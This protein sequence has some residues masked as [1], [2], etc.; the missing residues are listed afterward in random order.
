MGMLQLKKRGVDPKR[1]TDKQCRFVAEYA[2]D[3]TNGKAA[4]IR[5]G[6]PAKTAHVMASR[7][8]NHPLVS[9]ALGNIKRQQL[10][11]I[12]LRREEILEQLL[13]AVTRDVKDMVDEDGEVLS[14]PDMPKRMR[15]MIDG[16]D[17]EVTVDGET[18]DRHIKTK[19]KL[20]PKLGAI[21]AGMKYRSLYAPETHL[22]GVVNL[23]WEQLYGETKQDTLTV[24]P[25]P[26]LKENGNG[27]DRS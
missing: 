15:C 11:A 6:Y 13:F 1:L 10:E 7:L 17:Q 16:F 22:H 2:V 8:L 20:S 4:A 25:V 9:Q 18:G 23:D 19:V 24:E 21:D 14:I 26:Q 12:D 5:A 3:M 27:K